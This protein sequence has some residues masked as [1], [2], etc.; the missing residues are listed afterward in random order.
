MFL[1]HHNG[2]SLYA[3]HVSTVYTC[4][5]CTLVGGF[6][7]L[8]DVSCTDLS[9]TSRM[10][11]L[12]DSLFVSYPSSGYMLLDVCGGVLWD[13]LLGE[14]VAHGDSRIVFPDGM[15]WAWRISPGFINRNTG[16]EVY[17]VLIYCENMESFM[18]D[19]DYGEDDDEG[20]EQEASCYF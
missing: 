10:E 18:P 19:Y 1:F 12:L 17:E 5:A 16:N 7:T 13:M 6:R 11:A 2:Q 8:S 9:L 3:D 14:L 15:S 20:E 4:C